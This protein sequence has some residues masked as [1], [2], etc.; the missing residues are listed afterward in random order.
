MLTV[1]LP[2]GA[3][4]AAQGLSSSATFNWEAQNQ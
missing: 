2:G 3:P 1:S 4:A